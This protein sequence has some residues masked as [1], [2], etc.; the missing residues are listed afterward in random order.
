MKKV[1]KRLVAWM[2]MSVM[3]FSMMIT[4]D[5]TEAYAGGAVTITEA[6]G[7]FESAYAEWSP[8]SGATAYKAYVRKASESSYSRLDD[9][10][11]RQY[12]SY[13]RVDAVGL[14]AGEYVIKV[15]AETSGGEVS[16]ETGT[17][18]VKAY[19]RSGFAFSKNSPTGGEGLGAYNNDG[20]LK[21]G[22]VVLYLTEDNK[23]TVQMEIGGTT[24]T[25]IAA[26][27]QAIKNKNSCPPVAIRIIGKVTSSGLSCADMKSA[28]AIGVKDASN[29]TFE[30]IGEDATIYGAGVAA[31][32]SNSIEIRNLGL[33]NWGGGS[34][35]DGISLKKT[36]NAWIHNVDFFYGDAG[37]DG[38]QAKGDGSMDL[39][40][41]SQYVTISYNHFWD[42]GKMSLCGMKSE[43]GPNWITYHHNWLDHTD[44][45]HPRIRT[46]SVHVYNNY[47]DG[48]S[49]Y[50]VGAA[51]SSEAFVENNY[52]RN[53]KYPMLI[54]MQGS[55]IGSGDGG[56]GTFS[57]EDGGMIKSYGNII[58]G[59]QKYVTYQENS[60]EFDAYEASSRDE[61]VPSTVKAKQGG[62]VYSN[63]D[64][65]SNIMY[66]YNVDDAAD[67]PGIVT[68][69]AGRMNGGDFQW[70]FDNSVDDAAYSLNTPLKTALNNYESSVVSIGGGAVVNPNELT[71]VS[72]NLTSKT[73]VKGGTV[74]LTVSPVPAKAA[75]AG[76]STWTSNNQVV[77]T[78]SDT[79]L[80]TA[81][82]EG[83]AKITVE[84]SGFTANC[85]ITVSQPITLSG[86]VLSQDEAIIT[87]GSKLALT[88]AGTPA[89]LTESYTV[90][91]ESSD[92]SVATVDSDGNV[93]AV[94]EGAATITATA[95]SATGS[96]KATC[97]VTVEKGAALP[98]GGMV[99][100]FTADGDDSTFYT[101]SG[102]LSTA[103]GTV[104]Y[105]GATLT[106]CLKLESSTKVSFTAPSKG[107][108]TLV[109][110]SANSSNI[111]IDGTKKTLTDGILTVELEAGDHTITK[112]D[113]ANLFYMEFVPEGGGS[114]SGGE[115]VIAITGLTLN[116]TSATLK[117]GG[118]VELTATIAPDN[119]TQSKSVNWKSSDPQVATVSGGKVTAISAGTTTITA[120]SVGNNAISATCTITVEG[121]GG[122]TGGGETGGGESGGETG[123]REK[124]NGF[125]KRLYTLA[126][127]RD[128]VADAEIASWADVLISGESNGVDAGYGF[129]FS[130]ETKGKNLSDGDFVEMLYL[131]F[132]DRA[133]DEGGKSAWVSQLEA[134]VTREKIF[135]GFVMSDEFKGVCAEYGIEVG[136]PE[137]V[138][139]FAEALSY[140]RNQNADLTKFVARCYTKALGRGFDEDGIEAWCRALI[141]GENTPREVA[142]IG[143]LSSD[144][145]LA[146]NLNNEE[147]VKVLYRTFFD[148]EADQ[149]G[150]EAWVNTLVTGEQDRDSIL[151]GFTGSEEFKAVLESFGLN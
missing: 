145:F 7:W 125:V 139:A 55:D 44:S 63:F 8:V 43:S 9:E 47:Y 56:G 103:K 89:N 2:L 57:S 126:L 115:E 138:D 114:S 38:D 93:T 16:S 91:W 86:V 94:A 6:A 59:A 1:V 101:I 30:G 49:K 106:Q 113:T 34:D 119:T 122:S 39:K 133:S 104:S 53:C 98:T 60:V 102:N 58:I 45:R 99:H 10:L 128:G 105:K 132:M 118:T 142:G 100:N 83:T 150:L 85:T 11:I 62:R 148:R 146:K 3:V 40:D 124:V 71:G 54:S 12:P 78:V 69:S 52:F 97:K 61:K 14:A 66:D 147:F 35:G 75:L 127:G 24:Y 32:S 144:E 81:V 41:N 74:Q 26:I 68:S 21:S 112:A 27:T 134:G 110:N 64:T 50:G 31:F 143:F 4:V 65:D 37:K 48:V 141:T 120:T 107:T 136:K 140:Y 95:T 46:M 88:A 92:K 90:T 70:A 51:K 109:F 33:M 79:G 18:T 19:D 130:D 20:T 72:L 77:A 80:V 96:Y 135:E 13:W 23:N 82:S 129:V 84:N 29:V 117:A 116:K 111:K 151:E 42:S 15:V 108:L 87:T 149:G 5:T 121:D 137:D 73:L 22:A 76:T 17:L 67:V 123:S 25:G 28:Y 131:T 36:L